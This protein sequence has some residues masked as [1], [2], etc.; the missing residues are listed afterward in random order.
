MNAWRFGL[1]TYPARLHARFTA[2]PSQA[3]TSRI[4]TLPNRFGVFVNV[5]GSQLWIP[6]GTFEI[7]PRAGNFPFGNTVEPDR[8]A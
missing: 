3:M 7:D 2:V 1:N 8:P 4:Q 6:R 5:G